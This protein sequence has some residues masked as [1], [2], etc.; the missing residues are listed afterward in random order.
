MEINDEVDGTI[1][2]HAD[3][4]IRVPYQRLDTLK[5]VDLIQ[6]FLAIAYKKLLF[7]KNEWFLTLFLVS[8]NVLYIPITYLKCYF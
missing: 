7:I 4:N 3:T 8:K 2:C 5:N 6:Q 1:N